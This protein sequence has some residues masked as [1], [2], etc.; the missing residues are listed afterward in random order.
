MKLAT[1]TSKADIWS[2]FKN[3]RKVFPHIRN[4]YLQRQIE[5]GNV[6]YDKGVVLITQLYK[7]TVSLGNSKFEKG[8][9]I[10]HQIVNSKHGNGN[11]SKVLNKF[12]K[13]LPKNTDCILTVRKSNR[14]ARKF[15]KKNGFKT[16]GSINWSNN[17]IEGLI[18]NFRKVA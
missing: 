4:D 16:I 1:I 7:R 9:H 14:T 13:T 17:S 8:T 15:Y 11:A 3:H 6:I 18:Y 12:I 5:S 2:I 10:I